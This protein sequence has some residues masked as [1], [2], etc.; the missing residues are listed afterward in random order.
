[1]NPIPFF[2]YSEL[3]KRDERALIGVIADV[4]SRGAFILQQDCR[5]FEA[6][7]ASYM[8]VKHALGLANGTDAIIIGLRAVGIGPGDQVILPSHTYIATAAAVHMVGATPVLAECG[9]DHM[10]DIEDVEKRITARTRAIMPVQINGRTCDMAALQAVADSHGLMIVED[11][12]QALGSRFK[13]QCAGTFGKFGTIS[14]YPA[15]LLGCFGDGGAIVT[16]DDEVAEQIKLLRDHGRNEDGKVVAW[17][18]N[19]RLDNLQAAVLNHRFKAYPAEIERRR[20]V[21][22]MYDAGL[23][24]VQELTLPPAPGVD[25]QHFDVYQ[26]YELEGDRRDELKEHLDA[27]GV[28]TIIQWAGTPVHQFKDLGFTVSL[29]RTDEVFKRCLMLPMNAAI[30]DDQVET[31]IDTVRQFYGR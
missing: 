27:H 3:F 9:A 13:D 7:L 6:T 31:I 20:T 1:M 2:P 19:S 22:A 10:L 4:C 25:P 26:N 8:G 14:F 16:N 17:G 21:A 28:S 12:A 24:D 15:K 29:P 30:S 11:A 18:Y 23:G 5:D